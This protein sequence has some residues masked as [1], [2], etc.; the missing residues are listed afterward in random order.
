M[1][2]RNVV[3]SALVVLLALLLSFSTLAADVYPEYTGEPTT[4]TMWAWTSNENYSIEE[5][6]KAYPDIKV[7]WE[8]FG[9][10]YDKALTALAAGSGLPDVLMVEYTYSTQYMDLGAFQPINEWL[11]EETFVTLFGEPALQ[12]CAL[13]GNIYGTPQDSGALAFFYRQDIFD[14]YGL[15]VPETWDDFAEQARKLRE[16]APEL[17]FIT[18]PLDFWWICPIWQ[19]GTTLFD[20]K[21]GDWYINYTNPDAQKVFDFWGELIDEGIIDLDM[22]WSADWYNAINEGRTASILIGAWF[23]EWLK[24]NAPDTA[25]NWRVAM[26]PQW[27]LDEPHNGV[28]G[29]SGFYVT[30]HSQNPE[31]AAIFVT[32]LNSHEKSLECLYKYSNLPVM[33]SP[34][35]AEVVDDVAGPDEFFGGQNLGKA[36][37]EAHE[38][39]DT[40]FVHLPIM[41]NVA[42]SISQRMQDYVDGKINRF[43][44][45]LALWE[46]DTI[47]YMEEFG[48]DNV[49]YGRLP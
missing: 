9:V 33:V 11:D 30:A 35:F 27:D 22:W 8:N 47:D 6:E 34:R 19:A 48:Y 10:H 38:M 45:I 20:Y 18:V 46:Q 37:L 4:I 31:A 23:A 25:G 13:D 3:T 1:R 2:S 17:D 24:L 41:S 29:G 32:W 26:P 42:S 28:T 39:V 5:F 7:Q 49:V 40:S 12:W 36:L 21:D 15:V 44:D 14:K 43:A 16:Q